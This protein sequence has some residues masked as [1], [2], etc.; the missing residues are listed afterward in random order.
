[1]TI[2]EIVEAWLVANGYD[3]LCDYE[4]ECGCG[5]N[6]LMPCGDPGMC[7]EAAHKEKTPEG[8]EFDE[9]F[10]PGKGEVLK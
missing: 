5:I 7:C 6:D 10:V 1:M 2:C 3:G 4:E 8:S 9:L